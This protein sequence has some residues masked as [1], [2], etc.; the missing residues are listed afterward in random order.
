MSGK[1][2]KTDDSVLHDVDGLP[3]RAAAAT[4]AGA[5]PRSRKLSGKKP[6]K[7]WIQQRLINYKM[8]QYTVPQIYKLLVTGWKNFEELKIISFQV[9]TF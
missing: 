1:E 5:K 8:L 9:V 7:Y 2:D 4:A 6:R 3:H